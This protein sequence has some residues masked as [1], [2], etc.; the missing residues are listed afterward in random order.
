MATSV[1]FNNNNEMLPDS[2]T[3]ANT[4]QNDDINGVSNNGS[5][6]PLVTNILKPL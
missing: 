1:C 2:E 4:N 5:N 6:G 3:T